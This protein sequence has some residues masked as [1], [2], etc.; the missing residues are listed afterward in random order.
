MI[1]ALVVNVRVSGPSNI[2]RGTLLHPESVDVWIQLLKHPY[3]A[4]IV[5]YR[6][7]FRETGVI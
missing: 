2:L 1:N 3:L 4:V 7:P 5:M 6:C